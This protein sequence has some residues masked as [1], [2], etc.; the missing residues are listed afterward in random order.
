MLTKNRAVLQN[1]ADA[2]QHEWLETNGLGGWASSSI[3]G[4]N[5]RRYHGLLT[6]AIVPPAERMVLLSKLDET[7]VTG[8]KRIEL[9]VNVYANNIV[10]PLGHHYL[11]RFTKELFP[12]WEYEVEGIRLRKTIAMVN[13]ENTTLIIYDVVES[14]EP[15]TLELLPLMAARGY[16]SLNHEGPQMHWDADFTDGI[17]HNQPDGQNHVFISIP[18]AAY[19][20]TPRWFNNFEYPVEQYRGLD[21]QED[22]FNHGTFSVTLKQGDS[23]GIIISTE[24]VS[25]RNAHELLSKEGVRRKLLVSHQ[26]DDEIV[27]Q[28]VL[29]ADQFIV[30]RNENLKTVI[31]GYHWFTDWGRDTM[32][33]LP[34][35]CLSTG[36]YEDAKK[37]LAA[38]ADSVSMGMLPNRFQDNGEEP[39]YNNV[40]GTLW[41]F[42]AVHKYLQVTGDSDFV[43][44]NILPVLKQ[45]I[46]WHFAGTRY[47]IH[48][49]SDGL[50]FAG[51][52]GQQLTWMDAR[53]GQWVVTPRMGKPVEVQA[54]WYNALRIFSELLHLNGQQGDAIVVTVSAEK[55]KENFENLF[56]YE[57][58]QYLYDNI[59]E[60]GEPVTEFRPNQLF[61]ISLP[62]ALIEGDKAIS[63]LQNVEE[64]LYTPVGLRTLPKTDAHYVPVYGGDQ[65]H[66]DSAYHEGT[67]WSWLLGPYIDALAKVG[68]EKSLLKKVI[69]NFAY[70]L[71]EGCIGSVSEIFD[72]EPPHHPRGCI[73]QAWGVAELLR[74]IKD[75]RLYDAKSEKGEMKMVEGESL[76]VG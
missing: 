7:I 25:G 13:G 23:I 37:I 47:N 58:G 63:I 4:A 12:E 32:I 34:G 66:R 52:E 19:E 73:A 5:T 51:E 24:D 49:E 65:F 18:G 48:A 72:A 71:N 74:V 35:L 10:A 43:L 27:Q 11:N 42:V 38:F 20:H 21:F 41:Y 50:L 17:F 68:V 30:K 33:S 22:L 31:A 9:G 6:A 40:D 55:I 57:Q 44:N 29:A 70:H 54:L 60:K 8:D 36:R 45:I 46:D 69:D 67:V 16:H 14:A 75:Y 64:H 15:F 56:W 28:L 26:P 2:S 76:A 61:A 1:F 62:F 3:I 53:I 39:E 59:N